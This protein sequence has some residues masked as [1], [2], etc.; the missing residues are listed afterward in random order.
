MMGAARLGALLAGRVFAD[1]GFI[2]FDDAT[3]AAEWG[4]VARA[5]GFA[6]AVRHEPSGFVGNTQGAV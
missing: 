2:D 4:K 5:H 3:I 6:D 1:E